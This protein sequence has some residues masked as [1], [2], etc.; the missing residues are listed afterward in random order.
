MA[1]DDS[2]FSGTWYCWHWYPSQ[3]DTGEDTTKNRMKAYQQG[4]EI[5]FESEPNDEQSY[6]FM[7]LSVDGDVATGTWH[8]SSSPDGTF[9]GAM[10][11]GAGQLVI[12]EDKQSMEG[13][14]AG[15]GFDRKQNKKRIYTG[16]WKL[17]RTD[18]DEA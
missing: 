6:M 14:W 4:R 8:E 11:N 12:S 10:Y 3:D 1:T 17:S 13:Q 18:T 16:R 2:T 15:M 5:I 7:R 9:E